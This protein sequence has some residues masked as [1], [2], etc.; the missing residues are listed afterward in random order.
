MNR[1]AQ[2][3][4]FVVVAGFAVITAEMAELQ[5]EMRNINAACCLHPDHHSGR[6]RRSTSSKQRAD[7]IAGSAAGFASSQRGMPANAPTAAPSRLL[8][9]S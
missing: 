8:A 2:A 5:R 3:T 9:V 6:R 1:A 7:E 4:S